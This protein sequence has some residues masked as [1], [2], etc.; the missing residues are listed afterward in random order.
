MAP[1]FPLIMTWLSKYAP[2]NGKTSGM[3][4]FAGRIGYISISLSVSLLIKQNPLILLYMTLASG[5]ISLIIFTV[6]TVIVKVWSG[7]CSKSRNK[8]ARAHYQKMEMELVSIDELER[9]S[10]SVPS[11]H[12][13]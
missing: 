4:I 9:T 2:S 13:I 5:I 12:E 7:Q 6:L 3:V 10:K 1:I 8:N 11:E